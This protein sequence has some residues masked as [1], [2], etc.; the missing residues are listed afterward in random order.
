MVHLTDVSSEL[1]IDLEFLGPYP[2]S[3]SMWKHTLKF[4]SGHVF[5]TSVVYTRNLCGT[6]G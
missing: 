4:I 6:E 2:F 1:S 3:S 5:L